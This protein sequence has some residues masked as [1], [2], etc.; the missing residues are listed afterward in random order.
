[1]WVI[2]RKNNFRA[3]LVSNKNIV[4]YKACKRA[5]LCMLLSKAQINEEI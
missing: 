3:T 4:H 1:M 5:Y 2:I